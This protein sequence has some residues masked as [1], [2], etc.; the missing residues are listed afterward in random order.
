MATMTP[1]DLRDHKKSPKTLSAYPV[2]KGLNK[3]NNHFPKPLDSLGR[4]KGAHASGL[5][6]V[7]EHHFAFF[8]YRDGEILSDRAFYGYLFCKLANGTLS[9][10]C[11][12]HWHPSHKGLHCKL[13][14][15]TTL[16]YSGRLLVNAPEL[17]LNIPGS[18]DPA[19]DSDR[20]VLIRLFCAACGVTIPW[21]DEDEVPPS[22]EPPQKDFFQ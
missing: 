16:N 21:D 17:D 2:F 10:I 15:N 12:F 18:L 11:E 8:L 7:S 5:V 13:P 4:R 14:C 19:D 6:P 20:R 9:P 22:S 1:A 3:K